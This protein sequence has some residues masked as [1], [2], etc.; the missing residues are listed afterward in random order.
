MKN[1]TGS[2][3]FAS[4]SQ[5]RRV[6]VRNARRVSAKPFPRARAG[7][8]PGPTKPRG[9]VSGVAGRAAVG[10]VIVGSAPAHRELALAPGEHLEP[11]EHPAG[12]AD[13][14]DGHDDED[15]GL[16]AR[17]RRAP[18]AGGVDEGELAHRVEADRQ[19]DRPD[20][21]RTEG[22]ETTD[23][24]VEARHEVERPDGELGEGPRLATPGEE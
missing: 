4:R 14:D 23:R 19:R 10:V 7:S 9:S 22:A 13:E 6:A 8:R 11:G 24:E 18:E 2:V 15:P 12:D 20:G 16:D 1:R 21:E 3:Q 17:R 5:P